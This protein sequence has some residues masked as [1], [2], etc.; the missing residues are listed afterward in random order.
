MQ[1][2]IYSNLVEYR[3]R[4]RG[5]SILILVS[6]HKEEIMSDS[7]NII[8]RFSMNIKAARNVKNTVRAALSY[9]G[10][11]C[12]LIVYMEKLNCILCAYLRRPTEK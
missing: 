2:V 11:P 1:F 6:L 9:M 12:K 7:T 4:D 5:K 3:E 8:H 10:N